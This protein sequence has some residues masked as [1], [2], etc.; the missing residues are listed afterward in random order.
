VEAERGRKVVMIKRYMSLGFAGVE[1]VLFCNSM[2]I[3]MFGAAKRHFNW[4][5]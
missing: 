4:P 3:F 2:T 1:W 5:F